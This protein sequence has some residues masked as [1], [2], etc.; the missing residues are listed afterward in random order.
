MCLN[1][2]NM[3]Q[4]HVCPIIV[5]IGALDQGVQMSRV[6]FKVTKEAA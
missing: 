3:I 6:D 5:S 1:N 4:V 2:V